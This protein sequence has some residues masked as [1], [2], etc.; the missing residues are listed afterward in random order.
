MYDTTAA[1]ESGVVVVVNLQDDAGNIRR[2]FLQE[3]LDVVAVDAAP[4][5]GTP[6][7]A[8]RSRAS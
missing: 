3:L 8:N 5:I 6:F 4:S 1:E 7:G 2:V